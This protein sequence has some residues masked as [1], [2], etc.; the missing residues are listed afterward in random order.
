MPTTLDIDDALMDALLAR[1]P[2]A[3]KRE[4]VE[5]AI[6]AYLKGDAI[7]QLR[8][9]RGTIAIEDAWEELRRGRER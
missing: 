8:G 3:S 2:G 6:R 1:L 7:E 9:L 5:Q 4:A